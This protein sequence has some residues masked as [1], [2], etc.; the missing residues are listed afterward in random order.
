MKG[1]L[2]S[3]VPD[4]PVVGPAAACG[5]PSF[6]SY[7]GVTTVYDGVT[8]THRSVAHMRAAVFMLPSPYGPFA[9]KQ[10]AQMAFINTKTSPTWRRYSVDG[11]PS[12]QPSGRAISCCGRKRSAGPTWRW[13]VRESIRWPPIFAPGCQLREP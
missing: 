8:E 7:C 9:D 2:G 10:H 3:A 1:P 6:S 13:T 11:G 4:A 5:P 12:N